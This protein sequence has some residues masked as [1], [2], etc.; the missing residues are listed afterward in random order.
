MP[1]DIENV[2]RGRD[3]WNVLISVRLLV[4]HKGACVQR[5]TLRAVNVF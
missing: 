5:S 2:E 4:K 3:G 1:F